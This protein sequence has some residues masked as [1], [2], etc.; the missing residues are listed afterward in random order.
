[1][2][3]AAGWSQAALRGPNE[4]SAVA[5]IG[6]AVSGP[7]CI[8]LAGAL[9]RPVASAMAPTAMASDARPMT[10]LRVRQVGALLPQDIT[11]PLLGGLPIS[12]ESLERHGIW[13]RR[14]PPRTDRRGDRRLT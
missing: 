10:T 7:G 8:G 2:S 12:L 4:H 14:H 1:M 9:A 6:L 5:G 3:R 13:K 11:T